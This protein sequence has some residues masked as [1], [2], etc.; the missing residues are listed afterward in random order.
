MLINCLNLKRGN[1]D[2]HNMIARSQ[3]NF[4]LLKQA[5]SFQLEGNAVLLK[6]QD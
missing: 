2:V 3:H 6:L 4:T 1:K 5:K